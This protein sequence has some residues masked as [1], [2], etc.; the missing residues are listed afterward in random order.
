ML[1]IL[2]DL[3]TLYLSNLSTL[4]K[5]LFE[6]RLEIAIDTNK[7]STVL[8]LSRHPCLTTKIILEHQSINWDMTAVSM[9]SAI[10]PID[11]HEYPQL[12]WDFKALS[13]HP[14]LCPLIVDILS[15]KD[16][17]W[18]YLAMN[19]FASVSMIS[20]L[21][22]AKKFAYMTSKNDLDVSKMILPGFGDCPGERPIKKLKIK[23]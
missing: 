3:K 22:K 21:P 1:L 11:V 18:Q 17:D 13:R 7:P 15:D 19:E 2:M 4:A 16:W 12:K 8:W 6:V 5:L 10:N 14:K 20:V 23:K 9:N